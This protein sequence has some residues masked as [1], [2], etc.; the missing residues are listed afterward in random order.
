MQGRAGDPPDPKKSPW[1]GAAPT[2]REVS[3]RDA[4]TSQ[5]PPQRKP[6][7]PRAV[8]WVN[9]PDSWPLLPQGPLLPELRAGSQGGWHHTLPPLRLPESTHQPHRQKER[10]RPDGG[11]GGLP[12]SEPITGPL[13]PHTCTHRHIRTLVPTDTHTDC[14]HRHTRTHTGR[15]PARGQDTVRKSAPGPACRVLPRA[16]APRPLEGMRL[17]PPQL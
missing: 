2:A 15:L 16:P 7:Q 1:K 6:E 12:G 17:S 8:L 10:G 5:A 14:S 4:R 11:R 13:L 3:P 9:L